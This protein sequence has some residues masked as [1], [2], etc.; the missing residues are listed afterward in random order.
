MPK[1]HIFAGALISAVIGLA[2]CQS[3]QEVFATGEAAER[4]PGPCPRAFA[5]YDASRT[6]EFNG[7]ES[8]SNVGFTAEISRVK[9]LC[10]YYGTRPIVADLEIEFEAG[11]GP[12]ADGDTHDYN[13]FVAVTRKNIAVAQKIEFPVTVRFP[14]GADRV[15]V[16]ERIDRIEIPRAD[17]GT[18]GENF[19][20]IVGYVLTPEQRA[21]NADGKRFRPSAGQN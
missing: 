2:G 6:V 3:A 14:A 12:A 15:T 13:M 1:R 7:S 21:F 11:R 9:S 10:R 4:N 17:E 5:I 20:I 19:E 16:N 8:F 18:S